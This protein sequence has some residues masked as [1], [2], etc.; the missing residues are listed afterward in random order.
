MFE[1][2]RY[3]YAVKSCSNKGTE[4]LETL[5]NNMAGEGWTLY[6]LHE[7]ESEDD[8]LQYNCIF[9]KEYD[10]TKKEGTDVG[11]IH[12]FR[13]KM[14]KMLQ[15][16]SAPYE[17]Y[18]TIQARILE[19]QAKVDD[20]RQKIDET[21][22][23][24]LRNKLNSQMSDYLMEVNTLKGKLAEALDPE[25][26]YEF[27]AQ[28]KL[29]IQISYELA[30]LVNTEKGGELISETVGLR[31][32]LSSQLGYIYPSVK[33]EVTEELEPNEY[34]INVRGAKIFSGF[35][36]PDCQRYY[37]GQSNISKKPKK[38]IEEYDGIKH[39]TCF[40]ID[41]NLTKDY[42]EKGLTPAQVIANNLEYVVCKCADQLL[43]YADINNYIEIVGAQNFFL[44]ETLIA[45]YLS[46]G[47]IRAILAKLLEE[48]VSVK[49]IVYIF[50]KMSDFARLYKESQANDEEATI[51]VDIKEV[52][53][54]L[55]KSL[56]RNICSTIA[57]R[58]DTIFA[59]TI[60]D[61]FAKKLEKELVKNKIYYDNAKIK[62]FIKKVLEI[63]KT[64]ELEISNTI[65][66]V[67]TEI[68]RKVFR[69]IENFIPELA[70][71][72]KNEIAGEY[73]IEIVEEITE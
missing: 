6:M 25:K 28:D 15:P 34:R 38:A 44:V 73:T 70:V 14:E 26:M 32:K 2:T 13:S 30:D 68:R 20:I 21:S 62:S 31:Q 19:F 49:D 57:D 40:W 66:I 4:E 35:V 1:S 36:Y 29:S 63:I 37:L 18:K 72:S 64:N 61:A 69:L 55:R 53:K 24:N 43:D 50:E 67:P 17:E 23:E 27:V 12:S 7:A 3:E 60:N 39:K 10:D 52:L 11:D 71:I 51:A 59:I 22:D 47:E 42:W 9:Q 33:F 5:L 48:R 56:K 54:N 41:S 45:E 58:N 8:E 46:I 16:S 65:L